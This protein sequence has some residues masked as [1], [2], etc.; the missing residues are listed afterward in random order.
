MSSKHNVNFSEKNL[1]QHK[2]AQ[3]R[4]TKHTEGDGRYRID[5]YVYVKD[6]FGGVNQ[7]EHCRTECAVDYDSQD[8]FE[9]C[10]KYPRG[11]NDYKYSQ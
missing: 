11:N 8:G 7:H 10:E 5:A 3:P 1:Q 9:R 4:D 6:G 2:Q